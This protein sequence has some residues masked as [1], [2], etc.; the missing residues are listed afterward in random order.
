[1]LLGLLAIPAT[2]ALWFI[3]P[4]LST[5]PETSRVFRLLAVFVLLDFPSQALPAYLLARRAYRGF[6]LITLLFSLTRTVSLA[7]PAMLGAPLPT[8]M[9]WFLVAAGL[10]LVMYR[11]TSWESRRAI[12]TGR[13]SSRGS[14][15]VS[16]YRCRWPPLSPSS[17]SRPTNTWC[18]WWRT[19]STGNLYRRRDRA[20]V[21]SVAGLLGDQQPGAD[22]KS[23]ARPRGSG[24]FPALLA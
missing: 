24:K 10:R 5:S 22:S 8:I 7:L 17:T 11:A 13:S 23:G 1:M 6:F 4:L 2:L 19:G 3:G 21:G 14:C 16:E 9:G 20:S 15:S 12:W 18:L